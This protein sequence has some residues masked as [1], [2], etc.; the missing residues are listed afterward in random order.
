MGEL[1]PIGSEKLSGSAKMNRI[2][3]LTYY[4]SENNSTR[5]AEIVKES[6][7][8]I[9]GIVKE[10]DGYYVKKGLNENS[11]DYIGGLFMKNKNKF[12]SYGEAYKKLEFLTEQE[13]LQEATKYVLKQNKPEPKPQ[14]ESPAPAPTNE[15]PPPAATPDPTTMDST[16]ASVPPVPDETGN[17][18]PNVNAEEDFLRVIQKMTGKLTQKLSAFQDKLESKDIKY[19]LNM[20][21]AAVDLDKLEETDR[22]E[23]LDKFEDEDSDESIDT[24]GGGASDDASSTVAP[25]GE[26]D[27]GET[28][29]MNALEE[30]INTPFEDSDSVFDDDDDDEIPSPDLHDIEDKG[31]SRFAEKDYERENSHIDDDENI[32]NGE[33]MDSP[34]DIKKDDYRPDNEEEVDE[35]VRELDIDELTNMVNSTVKDSLSKYFS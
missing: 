28:D 10:K 23:I 21:L 11:L 1:K 25:A 8:G 19:V 32:Y 31:A 29:G 9:Y 30:L 18:E 12:Q 14:E 5:T 20:V 2:L 34:L 24:S 3:E 33:E 26:N 22:E 6:K 27:L 13:K 15:L 35:K 17:D 4:Q 7:T 16:D